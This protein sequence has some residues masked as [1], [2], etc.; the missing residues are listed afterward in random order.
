MK[1]Q[2]GTMPIS[3]PAPKLDVP[4]LALTVCPHYGTSAEMGMACFGT[5]AKMGM[6][7]FG[8]YCILFF[9]TCL[10]LCAKTGHPHFSTSGE[11]YQ[12]GNVPF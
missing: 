10:Q 1:P 7:H 11:W 12:N 5:G 2:I 4:I 8:T 3:A 9:V 6:S